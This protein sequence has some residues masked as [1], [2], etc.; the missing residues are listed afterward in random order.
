[1]AAAATLP[2]VAAAA[3]A[4]RVLSLMKLIHLRFICRVATNA[5][6]PRIWMEVCWAPTKAAGLAVLSQYLWA[7]REVC[8]RKLFGSADMLHV[9]RALFMFVHGDWFVNTRHNPTCLAGVMYFYTTRQGGGD[10]G[11]NTTT[12]E[13][14]LMRWTVP[15]SG[16]GR[17]QL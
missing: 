2:S 12:M 13:V 6:I 14:R 7:G 15:T 17:S 9:C 10:M 3:L 5:D 16:T 1:M 11:E 4:V 8:R